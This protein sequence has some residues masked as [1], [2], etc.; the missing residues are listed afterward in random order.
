MVHHRFP[1]GEE[2]KTQIHSFL[3]V[4]ITHENNSSR[5]INSCHMPECFGV[6]K[7]KRRGMQHHHSSYS[8]NNFHLLG[9]TSRHWNQSRST[10]SHLYRFTVC[11]RYFKKKLL[12]ITASAARSPSGK[13]A[14]LLISLVPFI[15]PSNGFS[16]D[17]NR[18]EASA[19]EKGPGT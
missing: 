6:I 13:R 4:Q 7:T 9:A 11:Y 1:L 14:G 17:A 5:Q 12:R 15:D 2:V 3:S 18:S 16:L 19:S 8:I 10:A